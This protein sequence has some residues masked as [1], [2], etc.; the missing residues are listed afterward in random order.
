MR[1]NERYLAKVC[2]IYRLF[3]LRIYRA[4]ATGNFARDV[5]MAASKGLGQL[6]LEKHLA[7]AK[8]M[9]SSQPL[10][11]YE[12]PG[13]QHGLFGTFVCK[14]NTS[15]QISR[16]GRRTTDS[17]RCSFQRSYRPEPSAFTY[18]CTSAQHK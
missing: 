12:H 15:H 14:P 16:F 7:E 13:P 1:A 5:G 8:L 2:V 10:G 4:W 3:L 9:T 18:I 6:G 11:S 17:Q